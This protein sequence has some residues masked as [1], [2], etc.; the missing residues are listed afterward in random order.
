MKR[1]FTL[2]F[3]CLFAMQ[4]ANAQTFSDSFESYNTTTLLGIQSPVWRTWS[5]TTGGGAEDVYVVTTDNH[6]TGGSQS[7]YFSSTSTTGGPQDVVLP[8]GTSPYTSGQLAFSSWFKIPTAASGYF[9]FQGN[10]TMGNQYVFECYMSNGTIELNEGTNIVVSG[11]YPE[12]AWFEVEIIA[13]LT[14]GNWELKV[15]TASVGTWTPTINSVW[16]IDYYPADDMASF[17]VDD[18]SYTYTAP[19]GINESIA[20]NQILNL[21]PNPATTNTNLS[22]ELIKETS[23]QY[24]IYSIDGTL[25][26]KTDLGKISGTRTISIDISTLSKGVYFVNLITESNTTVQKLIVQ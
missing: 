19:V 9:N 15:N 8:F 11:S 22:I 24:A 25:I 23:A 1:I 16:G 12:D 26:S 20:N 17:W 5:S 2:S 4:I 18:V 21:F 14:T 13:N 10:A 6:T 3:S 7:I